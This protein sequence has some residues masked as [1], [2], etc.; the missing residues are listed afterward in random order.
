MPGT[1]KKREE[2]RG[3]LCAAWTGLRTVESLS[4]G[5]HCRVSVGVG[6]A[7]PG[8]RGCSHAGAQAGQLDAAAGSLL[9]PTMTDTCPACPGV[10][11]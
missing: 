5:P 3:D 10:T 11:F 2:R 8:N 9:T 6:T 1:E 4:T 7:L